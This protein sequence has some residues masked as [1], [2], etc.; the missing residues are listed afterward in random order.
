[1]ALFPNVSREC[2][3]VEVETC[4]RLCDD[5]ALVI[6]GAVGCVFRPLSVT[7]WMSPHNVTL[8]YELRKESAYRRSCRRICDSTVTDRHEIFKF[9]EVGMLATFKRMNFVK[10]N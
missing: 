3:T 2:H 5:T 4:R 1:M 6:Y 7:D 8:C 10:N 9:N